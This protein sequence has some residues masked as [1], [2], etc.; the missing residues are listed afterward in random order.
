MKTTLQSLQESISNAV[1]MIDQS[2]L[3]SAD[4]LLQQSTKYS[5]NSLDFTNANSLLDKCEQVT[6]SYKKTKPVIRVIHN[7]ACSGGTLISKCLAA[8][9]NTFLL[10]EVHP[11]T[12]FHLG[13]GQAKYLPTDVISLSRYANIPNV[14]Q[15]AGDIFTSNIIQTSKH[16]SRY[17]GNLILRDHTYSDFCVGARVALKPAV[18][19]LLESHF[20]IKNLVTIRNPIDSY[21]SMVKNNWKHFEPFSFEEYCKRFIEMTECYSKSDIYR[22]EDFVKEPSLI[23]QSMCDSLD[24]PYSDYFMHTFE[25]FNVSGDSGRTSSI[26]SERPRREL[27][28][29]FL[30]EIQASSTFQ[31]IVKKFNY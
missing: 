27:S 7:L 15:L 30:L 1:D 28:S 4:L 17:A 12:E 5:T 29:E 18:F 25:L 3:V 20:Q 6:N 23:M 11:Y 22:Y 19:S 8:M 31:L 26:I 21:L 13:G 24:L 2:Q 14:E 16:V 10:S 9:P